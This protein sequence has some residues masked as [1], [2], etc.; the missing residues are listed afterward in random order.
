MPWHLQK[1][2][3]SLQRDEKTSTR[4]RYDAFMNSLS[5]MDFVRVIV[6]LRRDLDTVQ[7]AIGAVISQQEGKADGGDT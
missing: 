5:V 2:K 6:W 1:K 7:Q 4:E 3:E